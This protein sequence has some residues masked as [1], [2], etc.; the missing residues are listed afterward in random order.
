MTPA[1]LARGVELAD[2]GLAARLRALE[3]GCLPVDRRRSR[4]QLDRQ[5]FVFFAL[6]LCELW[7]SLQLDERLGAL[8]EALIKIAR[9][10]HHRVNLLGAQL[11]LILYQAHRSLHRLIVLSIKGKL[12]T[13]KTYFWYNYL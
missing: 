12:T 6:L 8:T 9:D 13:L 4:E 2:G 3:L 10:G 11:F 5:V 7:Q 1:L